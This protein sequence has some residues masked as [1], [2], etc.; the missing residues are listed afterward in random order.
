M[1][2]D[3]ESDR[4]RGSSAGHRRLPSAP[5]GPGYFHIY[6]KGQGYWTRMGTVAARR[7]LGLLTGDFFYTQAGGF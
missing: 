3:E 2:D 7:L 4:A 5:D 1:S 6:K